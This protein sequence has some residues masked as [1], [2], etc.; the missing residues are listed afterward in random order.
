MMSI[1]EG[2]LNQLVAMVPSLNSSNRKLL[3]HWQWWHH[4][5]GAS[6]TQILSLLPHFAGIFHKKMKKGNTIFNDGQ[7]LASAW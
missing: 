3:L 6:G 4:Y 7:V 1:P 5:R 2:S